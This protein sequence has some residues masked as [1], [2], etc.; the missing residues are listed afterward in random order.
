LPVLLLVSAPSGAGKTTV[1]QGLLTARP[2]LARAIT[3]TTR[4]PRPGE[5]HGRDYYF[6]SPE[7]F[8]RRVRNGEFLEHAVVYG[9]RYGT[10]RSE[11][12]QRLS[13]GQDVLLNIDVQGAASVRTEA[14]GDELIE[15]SLVTVFI[16]TASWAELERRL[17][18]RGTDSTETIQQRL[19]AAR[20]ELEEARHFNYLLV[21]G[22]VED[23]RR[24]L[25]AIYQAEKLRVDRV[26]LPGLV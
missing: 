20:S 11:V 9:H 4:P 24:R 21:S 25:E 18:G 17:A 23:D 16:V 6:L 13:S 5:V 3:C 22:S 15:R 7:E 8:E 2:A 1:C 26:P 19:A 14:V 10:W 12:R